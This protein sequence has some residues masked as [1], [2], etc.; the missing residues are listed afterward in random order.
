MPGW[1]ISAESAPAEDQFRTR[2]SRYNDF[3]ISSIKTN[4]RVRMSCEKHRL[5]SW[6]NLRPTMSAFAVIAVQ[7]ADRRRK[8]TGGG[9]SREGSLL[10]ERSDN[11]PIL[12]PSASAG[13]SGTPEGVA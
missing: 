7:F 12:A 8:T 2:V 6:Q 4:P 9:D 11:V 13:E 3:E 10:A 5:A 1:K